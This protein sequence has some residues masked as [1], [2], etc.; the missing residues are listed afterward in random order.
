MKFQPRS[1]PIGHGGSARTAPLVVDS[2]NSGVKYFR[3]SCRWG[4]SR[5]DSRGESQWMGSG[6]R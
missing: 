6:R 4:K 5:G 2:L 1:R 3:L